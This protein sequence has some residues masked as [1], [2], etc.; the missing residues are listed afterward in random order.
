MRTTVVSAES[1]DRTS[2]VTWAS[3]SHRTEENRYVASK[4][5]KATSSQTGATQSQHILTTTA[6]PSGLTITAQTYVDN[7]PATSHRQTTTADA[8]PTPYTPSPPPATPSPCSPHQ[9]IDWRNYTT[10][11][12]Y[13]DNK[14][15]YMYGCRTIQE[16]LDS[17]RATSPDCNKQK[18]AS[19]TATPSRGFSG[20]QLRRR[21]A[22][23][24]RCYQGSSMPPLRST[25][26]ERIGGAERTALARNWPRSA[27]QDSLPSAP[28]GVPKARA[29]S[30]DYLGKQNDSIL[31]VLEGQ[32]CCRTETEERLLMRTGDDARASRQSSS[33]RMVPQHHRGV[34]G[35]DRRG[36]SY[37][38]LPVTSLFNK[39][40]ETFLNSRAESLGNTAS[41]N[42][43]SLLTA[44]N[45]VSDPSTAAASYIASALASIQG[46][47]RDS[48][49]SVTDQRTPPTANHLP[50]NAKQ[51]VPRV[52]ADSLQEPFR[53]IAR[54][55]RSSSCSAVSKPHRTNRG[56]VKPS[57]CTQSQQ[58]KLKVTQPHE[59][60]IE[61]PDATVVVVCREK[62]GSQPI[63]PHSYILAVNETEGGAEPPAGSNVCWLPND[64]RREMHMRKLSDQCKASFCSNI[65]DSLDSIPFIGKRLL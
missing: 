5:S 43:P 17:L 32:T 6:Q 37:P 29:Y 28:S 63:R 22:S 50:H 19:T 2:H 16:R 40:T 8:S 15:L 52:R 39:G 38:G 36:G 60:G 10:Y 24:D 61:G 49:N 27:S 11:K 20:A 33:L 53:E 34:F 1:T 58:P 7:T 46:H 42:K 21:S 56:G 41:V 30:C 62:S 26:Q 31:S 3:P 51:S 4:D 9:N 23:H 12:E 18:S 55:G 64:A 13:I 54:G 48:S 44:K 65:D 25:S 57:N 47:I 45:Y 35:P 59:E 14:R